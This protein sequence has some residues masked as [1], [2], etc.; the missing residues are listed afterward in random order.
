[1]FTVKTQP[2]LAMNSSG[3]QA[4][5]SRWNLARWAPIP[6]RLIVSYGFFAHGVSQ[7]AT[8]RTRNCANARRG[9]PIR[10]RA[11]FD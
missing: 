5:I 7:A 4:L 2:Q 11:Y 9:S 6:L 10:N 1:M 8:A 3:L